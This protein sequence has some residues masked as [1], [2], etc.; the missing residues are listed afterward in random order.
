[1]F[2]GYCTHNGELE[3]V[4]KLF[5]EKESQLRAVFQKEA[6]LNKKSRAKTVAYIDKFFGTMKNP[7]KSRREIQGKCLN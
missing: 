5:L 2:R 3:A 4:K 7:K 6:L 1:M